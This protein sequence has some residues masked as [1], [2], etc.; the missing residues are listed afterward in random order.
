MAKT[1]IQDKLSAAEIYQLT[2]A[3]V[4]QISNDLRANFNLPQYQYRYFDGY[5]DARRDSWFDKNLVHAQITPTGEIV[6]KKWDEMTEEQ[7]ELCRRNK[8]IAGGFFWLKKD[9]NI[10][11]PYFVSVDVGGVRGGDK[12]REVTAAFSRPF[13]PMA[14]ALEDL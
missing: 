7:R 2:S 1:W 12:F 11:R 10:G 3:Q 8:M 9:G 5:I 14:V 6:A 13:N 4:N